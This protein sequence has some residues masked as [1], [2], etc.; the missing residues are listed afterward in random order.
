LQGKILILRV[1]KWGVLQNPANFWEIMAQYR[2]RV[3][4]LY[5]DQIVIKILYIVFWRMDL[6]RNVVTVHYEFP[7][8]PIISQKYLDLPEITWHQ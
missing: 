2:F 4:W 6:Q 8:F 5:V 7:L 3:I 1:R